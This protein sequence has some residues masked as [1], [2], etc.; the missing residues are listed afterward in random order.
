MG[1][2]QIVLVEEALAAL[3]LAQHYSSSG[4]VRMHGA[5]GVA[6][7]RLARLIAGVTGED[8]AVVILQFEVERARVERDRRIEARRAEIMAVQP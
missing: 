5:V 4:D 6:R 8:P 7:G 1:E 3:T 2:S